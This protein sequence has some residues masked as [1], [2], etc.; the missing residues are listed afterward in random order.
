MNLP[1]ELH[2]A[3]ME[4][5][6]MQM[7]IIQFLL[8]ITI[9]GI[10]DNGRDSL[11]ITFYIIVSATQRFS[12]PDWTVMRSKVLLSLVLMMS[13]R[14][15]MESLWNLSSLTEVIT[16]FKFY[17]LSIEEIGPRV[18]PMMGGF[19]ISYFLRHFSSISFKQ[20]TPSSMTSSF[21][22]IFP[23]N[24]PQFLSLSNIILVYYYGA[25]LILLFNLDMIL[26]I[27]YFLSGLQWI[28][29][30]SMEEHSP[31]PYEKSRMFLFLISGISINRLIKE[32]QREP[33][34]ILPI[35]W[36]RRREGSTFFRKLWVDYSQ[37]SLYQ[38]LRRWV[39]AFW[40]ILQK[41]Q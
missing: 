22:V 14:S 7:G 8:L 31:L 33:V 37:V 17:S 6:S 3:T 10:I 30:V 29:A 5:Y 12:P 1:M 32:L 18:I 28:L 35:F 13:K 26:P 19:F 16:L 38:S 25:T 36:G 34:Q 40:T 20:N 4:G 27:C 41:G 23:L 11:P 21:A 9:D 2:A 39:Q 24:T 15:L